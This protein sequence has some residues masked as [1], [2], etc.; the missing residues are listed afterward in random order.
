MWYR[1]KCE[2][3]NVKRPSTSKFIYIQLTAQLESI[4]RYSLILK[5]DSKKN[6]YHQ[7]SNT[8]TSTKAQGT[9]GFF[10]SI[11]TTLWTEQQVLKKKKQ[12]TDGKPNVKDRIKELHHWRRYGIHSLTNNQQP[13]VRVET[14]KLE[15]KKLLWNP[16]WI[17]IYLFNIKTFLSLLPLAHLSDQF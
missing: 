14:Q 11:P 6:R 1:Q 5:R 4:N 9:F 10:T 7:I 16:K 8:N 3:L 15:W 17:S 12:Q 13:S 2:M